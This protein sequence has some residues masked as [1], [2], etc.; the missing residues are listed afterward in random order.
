M[1]PLL[2]TLFVTF[3]LAFPAFSQQAKPD[4]ERLKVDA[5]QLNELQNEALRARLLSS[6][7]K[8]V[9]LL[10]GGFSNPVV[11]QLPCA[12]LA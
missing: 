12:G 6:V 5:K 9:A 10:G 3:L 7:A 4:A 8:S 1:N 2:P 11:N